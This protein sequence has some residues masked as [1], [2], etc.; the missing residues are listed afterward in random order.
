MLDRGLATRVRGVVA[1]KGTEESSDNAD[2]LPTIRNVLS[3]FLQ[4]EEGSLGV[5]TVP[6]QYQFSCLPGYRQ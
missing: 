3:S 6:C 2:D 4:D 5:D 1:G